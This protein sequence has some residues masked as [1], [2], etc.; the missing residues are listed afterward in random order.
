MTDLDVALALFQLVALVIP[1]IAVLIQML[2]KSQN[3]PWQL[4]KWSFGLV[5][6]SVLSF[7]AS[8][9]VVTLWVVQS[10]TPPP[11]LAAGLGLTLVGLLPFALFTAVLY[12]EHRLEHGP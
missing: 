6:L 3:L 12:R 9:A 11:L 7:I 10:L 8:G 5:I 1:P 2:R 4:R